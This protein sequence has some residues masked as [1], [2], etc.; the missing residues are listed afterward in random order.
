MADI[1]DD[2]QIDAD[3][4]VHARSVDVD[5][6]LLR[7]GRKRIEP[8]GHAIVEPRAEAQDQIGLVHRH[9]GFIGAVHP[10]HPQPLVG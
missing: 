9:I 6:D 8:P 3:I 5:M 10:Q 2:A 1:G 7:F 4:L